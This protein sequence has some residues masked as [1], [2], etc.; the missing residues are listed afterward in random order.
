M[1]LAIAKAGKRKATSA[2]TFT[3][4]ASAVTCGDIFSERHTQ[5]KF[6]SSTSRSA[7][8]GSILLSRYGLGGHHWKR[9][10][11]SSYQYLIHE[12][13]VSKQVS[14]LE[15]AGQEGGDIAMVG[16]IKSAISRS[17]QLIE[18]PRSLT[19]TT[20]LGYRSLDSNINDA[21]A[22]NDGD[23][24][25]ESAGGVLIPG[26][27]TI[28]SEEASPLQVQQ[29]SILHNISSEYILKCVE[30]SPL[31][32]L[33]ELS[34][35][36]LVFLLQNPEVQ[37]L[38][39]LKENPKATATD[40]QA[41]I[42]QR[43]KPAMEALQEYSS[44]AASASPDGPKITFGIVSNGLGIPAENDHPMHLNVSS[45]IDAAKAY[46]RFSTVELPVNLLEICG[47]SMARKLR[48]AVPSLDI[49]AMRPLTCYPDLGTGTGH[50]FRLVD[51]SLPS[52]NGGNS[53]DELSS[54]TTEEKKVQYTNEMAGIPAVYQIA[55]QTA[56]SHFDA[57]EL[58]E[59]KTE[60][61][62][63]TDERETLDGCKLVQSMIHDLDADLEY[64]RSFAAH[65][66]DLYGRII[67]LLYDTFEAMDD[68]TSDVLQAYFA[69]YGVA[70][71][72]A[73]A[74]KTRQVL[75]E[76]EISASRSSSSKAGSADASGSGG[77]I[78]F[79]SGATYPNIP[80]QMTLQEYALRHLMADK[81]LSRIVIGASTLQDFEHQTELISMI[82]SEVQENKDSS[83]LDAIQKANDDA[84]NEVVVDK[85]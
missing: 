41:Y 45:V 38:E 15:V 63:N 2:T 70:V 78:S 43:W 79:S 67:P 71:R 5:S 21:K 28:A 31:L 22:P 36:K 44:N 46:D 35:L 80:Q 52:F 85:Q 69:A 47:W 20:R 82:E 14:Y 9:F 53:L 48:S 58:L 77:N 68:R 64:V 51:Y 66:E 27:V 75:K 74:K 17:P 13:L 42:E 23:E 81:S 54:T 18:S 24:N 33:E 56:M 7:S 32:E 30:Q 29:N 55:L 6:F 16:A 83:P 19:I 61:D 34:K 72:Y 25:A 65:E 12:A 84:A 60:R 57:E 59:I 26:D 39:L 4:A 1:M 40:R 10:D 50:P 73:I 3:A 49:V 11:P 37:V 8:E 62:L 76:G